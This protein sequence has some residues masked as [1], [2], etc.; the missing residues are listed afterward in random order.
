MKIEKLLEFAESVHFNLLID[1]KFISKLLV[2]CYGDLHQG[3][4]PVFDF[5]TFQIV[6][7]RDFET[8]K[9]KNN[10]SK[11]L[12]HESCI[13]KSLDSHIS[14]DET[15]QR[16]FHIFLYFLKHFSDDYEIYGFRSGRFF[17]VPKNH[18]KTIAI[19]PGTLISHLGITTAP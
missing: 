17:E 10:K 1:T 15:V 14:K 12:V 9:L 3:P 6:T 7:F 11:S 18:L 13:F 5:S 16:R 8:S 19:G 2:I 4:V